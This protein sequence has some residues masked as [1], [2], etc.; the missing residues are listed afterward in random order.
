MVSKTQPVFADQEDLAV[1]ATVNPTQADLSL[2]LSASVPNGATV[3]PGTEIQYTISYVP[4]PN[5]GYPLQLVATWEEGLVLGTDSNYVPVFDYVI[6]SASLGKGG[7][8]PIIDLL[9]RTI[10]WNISSVSAQDVAREVSFKL[11]VKSSF[12][13]TRSLSAYVRAS[14]KYQSTSI[15]SQSHQIIIQ[16]PSITPPITLTPTPLKPQFAEYWF[17]TISLEHVDNTAALMTVVTSLD[18]TLQVRYGLCGKKELDQSLSLDELSSY[19]EVWLTELAPNSAYCV[20]IQALNPASGKTITSDIYIIK[21]AGEGEVIRVTQTRTMWQNIQL[22]SSKISHLVVPNT[23]PLV[24][25]LEIENPEAVSQ[26]N[27][28]FVNRSVLGVSTL[29]NRN[30][31]QVSF[32]EI[33]RG[34]FSAEIMSPSVRDEYL[35]TLS[36]T[37]SQGR[38][39]RTVVP[40]TYR[41]V[42]RLRVRDENDTPI[43]NAEVRIERYEESRK[44]FIP[45]KDAFSFA[46][47]AEGFSLPFHANAEGEIPL[48]LP[49]GTYRIQTSA[50]GYAPA[51]SEFVLDQQTK[52]YPIITLSQRSS[53]WTGIDWMMQSVNM[54]LRTF[55]SDKSLYFRTNMLFSAGLVLQMVIALIA[56]IGIAMQLGIINRIGGKIGRVVRDLDRRLLELFFGSWAVFNLIL[57]VFFISERGWI[58]SLPYIGITLLIIAIDIAYIVVQ[59]LHSFAKSQSET[60]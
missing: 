43:E 17:E 46:E 4:R 40:H 48:A 58:A 47:V 25:M 9:Q 11:K 41:I 45:L 52:S 53:L 35:F 6:G 42:D 49:L 26:I 8:E 1:T 30:V 54:V 57:T 23:I 24:M 19:H 36:I 60:P 12:I 39:T 13:T 3:T 37:D 14:G 38:F 50:I 59:E 55:S 51:V 33:A 31:E 5:T 15:T 29:I 27:G 34:V 20:Q 56:L 2:S 16:P 44:R 7:A 10:T 22:D 28:V 32:I 21:T 18:S